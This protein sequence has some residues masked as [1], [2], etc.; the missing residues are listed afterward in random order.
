MAGSKYEE[1]L[2]REEQGL[3]QVVKHGHFED[4]RDK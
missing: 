1:S 4:R 3:I 2:N